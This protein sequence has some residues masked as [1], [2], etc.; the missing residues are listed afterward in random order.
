MG[1]MVAEVCG[2]FAS[3]IVLVFFVAHGTQDDW[4]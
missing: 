3:Y 2:S 1:W 4:E